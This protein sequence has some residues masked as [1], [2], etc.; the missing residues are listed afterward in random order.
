MILNY[1]LGEGYEIWN[2]CLQTKTEKILH[3]NIFLEPNRVFAIVNTTTP[4]SLCKLHL[5]Y[6]RLGYWM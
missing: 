6:K 5:K 3:Y 2:N 1:L 4:T